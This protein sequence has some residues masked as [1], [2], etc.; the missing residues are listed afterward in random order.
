MWQET[1][2]LRKP[3]L[4][5]FIPL[6]LSQTV[7][8]I[9]KSINFMRACYQRISIRPSTSSK[10]SK[11]AV[12]KDIPIEEEIAPPAG[13]QV[14]RANKSPTKQRGLPM[15][16]PAVASALGFGEKDYNNNTNSTNTSAARE[17]NRNWEKITNGDIIKNDS[18]WALNQNDNKHHDIQSNGGE[19]WSP[20]A[21]NEVAEIESSLQALR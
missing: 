8:V 7:L 14:F 10:K 5:T 15:P 17:N 12:I 18:I 20:F 2:F 16:P 4:P 1:Y 6:S 9:G 21:S 11:Q 19:T 13:P 3:M